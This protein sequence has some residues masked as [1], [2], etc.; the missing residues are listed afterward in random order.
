MLFPGSRIWYEGAAADLAS[1]TEEIKSSG[2]SGH[3]VLEFQESIDIV[4]CVGGEFVKVIEKIGRS[5]LST[6]KYREIWGKCQIKPGRMTVFE[7]PPLLARRLR[8]IRGR[9]QLCAGSAASGCDPA[10]V[11]GDLKSAGFTGVLDVVSP[12]GKLLVDLEAG[13]LAACFHSEYTGPVL[14]GLAAFRAWHAAY[15]AAEQPSQFSVSEFASAAEGHLWDEILMDRAELVPLPL[16]PSPERLFARLGRTAAAGELLFAAGARPAEAY[17]LLTGEVELIAEGDPAPTGSRLLKPG[18]LLGVEWISGR[19]PA[20]ASARA[21]TPCR[22]L[23]FGKDALELVFANSPQ[24]AARCVRESAGVLAE[25]RGRLEA[26][27]AEPRLSDVESAVLDTLLRSRGTHP[28]GMPPAE[29]FRELTQRLPLSLPEIDAL[30]RKLVA[31]GVFA[32][33]GGRTNLLAREL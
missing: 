33:S 23:A 12:T 4:I 10:R 5:I 14:E 29:L 16:V 21:R 28:E 26:F 6:K 20:R 27:S 2:F 3:I 19:W 32:Q 7:L 30:F 22:Y 18:A 24:L 17:Y 31:L 8:G 9:R 15:V 25:L 1:L 13:V 11:L